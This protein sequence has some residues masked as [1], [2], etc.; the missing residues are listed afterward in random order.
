[1]EKTLV[2]V[3]STG[4]TGTR[5]LS[6]L[7]LDL[8][9]NAY[10]ENF[11]AGEPSVAIHAYT[12][13][14]GD[15]W[16]KDPAGYFAFRSSFAD[17][18]LRTLKT[19]FEPG[20]E[21]KSFWKPTK[22]ATK[23]PNAVVEC[24]HNLTLASPIIHAQLGEL[25]VNPKYFVLYRN[26]L[27]TIHALFK[28]EGKQNY[29]YRPS[30]FHTQLGVL[31]AAEVWKNSYRHMLDLREKLGVEY[32]YLLDLD[33]FTKD[34]SSAQQAFRFAGLPFDEEHFVHFRSR[35]SEE[36]IR[37]SKT[38]SIRNSDLFRDLDFVFDLD[39]IEAV[40][41]VIADVLKALSIESEKMTAEYLKFHQNEKRLN[42]ARPENGR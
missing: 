5:F 23:H 13:F 39:Q 12:N 37:T 25:E 34:I 42:V 16:M 28:A 4:R 3:L 9:F 14:L 8:G 36:P 7:F 1:M 26:P 32:F 40:T 30:S 11:Y 38:E 17:V 19:Q 22:H 21:R 31:G 41:A 24:G 29:P 15:L 33:L 18:Y 10:H 20:N 6:S 2:R 35:F 27:H